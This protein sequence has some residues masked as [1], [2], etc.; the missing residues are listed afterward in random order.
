MLFNICPIKPLVSEI[1]L[2]VKRNDGGK[3]QR[4]WAKRTMV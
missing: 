3:K 1:D 4:W 2:V